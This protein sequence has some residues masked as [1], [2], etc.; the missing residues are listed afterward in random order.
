VST[1]PTVELVYFSRCDFVGEAR[2]HLREAFARLGR[3]PTWQEWDQDAPGAPEAIQQYGSPTI[4]VGGR[5]VT[6]PHPDNHGR[7]CRADAIPS[8]E[9]IAEAILRG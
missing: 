6:G 1:S 5:D 4:L 8:P 9:V 2:A 7:A 3:A